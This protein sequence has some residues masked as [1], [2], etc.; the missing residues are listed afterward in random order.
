MTIEEQFNDWLLT[1]GP[2]A[3]NSSPANDSF[4]FSFILTYFNAL[5]KF[6]LES[7]RA[8]TTYDFINLENQQYS[9][10]D[11]LTEFDIKL[12]NIY[13]R[14]IRVNWLKTR[15]D[16][17][18]SL[19]KSPCGRRSTTGKFFINN[20]GAAE[21]TI[22][23]TMVQDFQNN[24]ELTALSKLQQEARTTSRPRRARIC[25]V[26]DMRDSDTVKETVLEKC[27]LQQ[28]GD[29]DVMENCP[30]GRGRGLIASKS[31]QK[32]EIIVD[33]HAT[34]INKCQ[35]KEIEDDHDDD[36]NNY[37]F[38][39][40]NGLFWDGSA[41]TCICH[42]QSRLLGRL[43]NFAAKNSIECNAK[44]QFVELGSKK[45]LFHAIILV[46]SRDI[47]VLEE[48]RFDYGDKACLELFK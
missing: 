27:M 46:A 4:V 21:W 25:S 15:K 2:Y 18:T 13:I 35:A 11:V 9:N 41:E 42:P 40:P 37:L 26:Y 29:V 44:P 36:R 31:F 23:T 16:S 28:W 20:V 17:A 12:L 14:Y 43:A 33:Y 3:N 32:N 5:K 24:N 10:W 7:I 38:S 39:G 34:A 30:G 6:S 8:F 22:D 45:H 47:A 1:I 19:M 48:I